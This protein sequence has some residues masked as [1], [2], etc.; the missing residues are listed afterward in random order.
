[1]MFDAEAYTISIRKEVHDGESYYVGR[2]AEFPTSA[3]LKRVSKKRGQWLS[4]RF[5]R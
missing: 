3:R 4:T 5:K 1:M 2:V